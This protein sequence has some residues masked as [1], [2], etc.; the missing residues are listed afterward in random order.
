MAISTTAAFRGISD[1]KIAAVTADTAATYTKGT[2]YDVPVKNLNITENRENYELKHDDQVQALESVLQ[3]ANISGS[4]ARIPM[5]VL[6]IFTGGGVTASG[7]DST[8][9][10]T[11]DL[12]Y[13]D[14]PSYFFL[15]LASAKAHADAGDVAD[16]HIQFKK[17]KILS[18]DYNIEDGFATVNFS[19]KAIRTIYDGQIKSVVFN[20]TATAIS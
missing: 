6:N 3:S 13:N 18:L 17:C 16:V 1:C 4:I 19:A 14:N 15:E 12:D 7:A 11:Y 10:Q 9:V 5:N 2:L 20:E 8:E